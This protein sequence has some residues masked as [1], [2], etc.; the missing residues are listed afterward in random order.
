MYLVI[1][2][3]YMSVD[4]KIKLQLLQNRDL[5]AAAKIRQDTIQKGFPLSFEVALVDFKM[6][7]KFHLDI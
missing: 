6:M 4:F 7:G 3:E 2:N 1:V 5:S